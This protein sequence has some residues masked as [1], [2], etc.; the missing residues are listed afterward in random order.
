MLLLVR[1]DGSERLVAGE[2]RRERRAGLLGREAFLGERRA[3]RP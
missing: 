2:Q 1:G 3:C